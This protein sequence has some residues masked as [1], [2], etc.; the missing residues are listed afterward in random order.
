[1]D[2]RITNTRLVCKLTELQDSLDSLSK[3]EEVAFR[4]T[5]TAKEVLTDHLHT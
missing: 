5:S 3:N 2:S 1:M 4:E